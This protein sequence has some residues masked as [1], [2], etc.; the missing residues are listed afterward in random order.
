MPQ[1]LAVREAPGGLGDWYQCPYCSLM[2]PMYVLNEQGELTDQRTEAPRSCRRCGSPM[3]LGEKAQ[4]FQDQK[5]TEAMNPAE[6]PKRRSI[7]I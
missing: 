6:G 7:T 5:G 4:K 3:E 1:E 2:L